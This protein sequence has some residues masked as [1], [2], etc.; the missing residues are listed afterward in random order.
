[1]VPQLVFSILISIAI[2]LTAFYVDAVEMGLVSNLSAL[3]IVLGGTFSATLLAYP[4]KKIIWTFQLLKSTFLAQ[5]SIDWTIKTIVQLTRDYRQGGIFALEYQ[6]KQLPQGL[7]KT[8]IELIA[9]RCSREKI[10][11]ILQKEAQLTYAQYDTGYK[12]LYS[13]ARLAPALGLTG[14]IV[15]LIRV[16]A[17]ITDPKSLVGYMAI[18]LMSTFYG[19]VLANLCFVPLANKIRE[20]MDSE[21]MELE[22]I[23]EGILDLYDEENPTAIQF[24]LEAISMGVTKADLA[25]RRPEFVPMAPE[26]RSSSLAS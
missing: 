14:T 8:S 21:E 12:I 19:V 10:Q 20:F 11:Q 1:M 24:K 3:M 17:H 25:W 16:F 5:K 18:A 7:L 26:K 9:I 22:L 2:F 4:W 23:Q 13:M 15:T 6:G